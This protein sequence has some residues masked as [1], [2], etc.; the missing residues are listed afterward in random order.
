MLLPILTDQ[1]TKIEEKEKLEKQLE[2]AT[3]PEKHEEIKAK[4]E[5][6]ENEIIQNQVAVQEQALNQE[7]SSVIEPEVIMPDVKVRRTDIVCEI[8]DLE[9]AFKK[10][11]DL[12]NIELKVAE[13]K[14][15]GKILQDAGS[16]GSKEELISNGI[17][18]TIKKQW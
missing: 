5:E 4:L 10:S 18:Y 3:D 8:V 12:L 6:K 16:F 13:A 1:K 14:K 2:K 7:S 17:K 9:L 11:R 15:I